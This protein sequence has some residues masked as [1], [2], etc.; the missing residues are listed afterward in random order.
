MKFVYNVVKATSSTCKINLE[1]IRLLLQPQFYFRIWNFLLCEDDDEKKEVIF[2][3]LHVVGKKKSSHNNLSK[4]K[5]A[6]GI[7]FLFS[8]QDVRHILL[9]I[10]FTVY[11]I[12]RCWR[13][14]AYGVFILMW[15]IRQERDWWAHRFTLFSV[16]FSFFFSSLRIFYFR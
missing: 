15:K 16:L 13:E 2:H 10:P 6:V 1:D 4:M 9:S 5:V 12:F 11:I 8:L 3:I 7:L 14:V